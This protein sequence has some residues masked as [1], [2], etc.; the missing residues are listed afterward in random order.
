MDRLSSFATAVLLLA[1]SFVLTVL[2]LLVAVALVSD[3]PFLYLDV[4]TEEQTEPG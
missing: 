3:E 4:P 2:L 1:L